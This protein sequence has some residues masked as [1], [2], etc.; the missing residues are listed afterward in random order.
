MRIA[1][2]NYQER[3]AT[4][5]SVADSAQMAREIASH[6]PRMY[7]ACRTAGEFELWFEGEVDSIRRNAESPVQAD[8]LVGQL[9]AALRA[10]TGAR[11]YRR[12][13]AEP[14]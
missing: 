3:L 4:M 2:R 9:R 10:L 11:G 13:R 12:D 7:S 6:I 1:G 14:R 5:R 8:E